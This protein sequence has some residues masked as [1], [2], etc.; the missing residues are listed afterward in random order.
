MPS[1]GW[2]G[3][4]V[5]IGAVKAGSEP[6]EGGIAQVLNPS[7]SLAEKGRKAVLDY[8]GAVKMEREDP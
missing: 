4:A 7:A 3:V 1:C 2:N 8:V 5:G 6:A